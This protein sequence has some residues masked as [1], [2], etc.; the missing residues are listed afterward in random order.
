MVG[1]PDSK[2]GA[3]YI[4]HKGAGGTLCDAGQTSSPCIIHLPP[5]HQCADLCRRFKVSSVPSQ[6][7]NSGECNGYL[8]F[9]IILSPS[10]L[11]IHTDAGSRFTYSKHFILWYGIIQGM[12]GPFELIKLKLWCR[13]CPTAIIIFITNFSLI[14]NRGDGLANTRRVVAESQ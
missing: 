5:T 6:G 14:C 7:A 10:R 9:P 2:G 11:F 12:I 1:F 8:V 3:A 13:P 4:E